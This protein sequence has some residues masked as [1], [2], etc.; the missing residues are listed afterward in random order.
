MGMDGAVPRILVDVKMAVTMGVF[1]G[2]HQVSM[3]VRMRMNVYVLMV[4]LKFYGI[5]YHQYSAEYHNSQGN[6]EL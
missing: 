4:V 5:L 3:T 6:I 2:V 1:M